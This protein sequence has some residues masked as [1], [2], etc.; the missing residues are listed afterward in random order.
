M[1]ITIP[2]QGGFDFRIS[3]IGNEQPTRWLAAGWRDFRATPGISLA[4][5][6]AF[7]AIGYAMTWGLMLMGLEALILPLATG[8]LLVAP[9]LV[10]GLYEVS[11]RLETGESVEFK[12]VCLI[13]L[14]N[15][16]RLAEMGVAMMIFLLAW[17]LVAA[18]LF[19]LFLGSTAPALDRLPD[20][21]FASP[22]G[23]PFL[24][25][26]TAVGAVF[27]TTAFVFSAFSIPLLADRDVDVITAIR[28][29]GRAVMG[30]WRVM[31]SWAATI[32]TVTF[33]GMALFF[34]GLAVALPVLAYAT[35]H[36][37]RDVVG[38]EKTA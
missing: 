26:G 16:K 9:V 11:R 27:A 2:N 20:V 33:V 10:A 24:V 32:A 35:W 4:Y 5:G 3:V 21:L 34:L 29:S 15:S 22:N 23:L 17:M 12:A 25:V 6:G 36:A 30:N 37:Y 8:F 1:D 31:A 28:I 7:V 18:I 19:A 13:C 14:R 38:T